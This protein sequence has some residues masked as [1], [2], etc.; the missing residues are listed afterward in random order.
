MVFNNGMIE[1]QHFRIRLDKI[2]MKLLENNFISYH[3]L[4][5]LGSSKNNVFSN[6][7]INRNNQFN[8]G[9]KIVHVSFLKGT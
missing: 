7:N 1:Y 2:V 6:I 4:G 3:L 9:G 8:G 5:R